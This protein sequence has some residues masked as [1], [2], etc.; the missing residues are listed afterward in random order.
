MKMHGKEG[1]Q[2]ISWAKVKEGL[3]YY[4]QS[5]ERGDSGGPVIDWAQLG[6]TRR[7]YFQCTGFSQYML[8][9]L[10]AGNTAK[11]KAAR[12]KPVRQAA[13]EGRTQLKNL[14]DDMKESERPDNA[15]EAQ[16][17][18]IEKAL[19]EHTKDGPIELYRFAVNPDSFGQTVENLFAIGFF[20]KESMAEHTVTKDGTQMIQ[21]LRVDEDT[22]KKKRDN[23]PAR[24]ACILRMEYSDFNSWASAI[25]MSGEGSCIP[26]RRSEN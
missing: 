1:R 4:Y 14:G 2:K 18:D 21:S 23:A 13:P 26:H 12:A 11:A 24:T 25:R 20:V 7:E 6:E 5:E 3:L 9:A 17:R 19:V 10:D 15:H 8:G 16:I 22:W